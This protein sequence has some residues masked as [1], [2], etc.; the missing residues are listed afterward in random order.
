LCR[1]CRCRTS[2]SMAGQCNSAFAAK[3]LSRLVRTTTAR[4]PNV[5]RRA[6]LRAELS[7]LAIF[8]RAFCAAH[9]DPR[10]RKLFSLYITHRRAGDIMIDGQPDSLDLISRAA[11]SVPSVHQDAT[12]EVE[13]AQSV[14]QEFLGCIA[15]AAMRMFTAFCPMGSLKPYEVSEENYG[16]LFLNS[17]F[18]TFRFSASVVMVIDV[19]GGTARR[20]DR[21]GRMY[22]KVRRCARRR[23]HQ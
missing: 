22:F 7:S 10:T 1:R 13:S 23:S 6:A 16:S 15:A 3:L 21:V 19:E 5:Q 4:T 2:L 18:P 17:L 14:K 8:Y 20:G 12:M 11:C 9:W